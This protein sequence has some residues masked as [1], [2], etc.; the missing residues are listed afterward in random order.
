M[1]EV[2]ALVGGFIGVRIG[3]AAAVGAGG[4]GRIDDAAS[5]GGERTDD[6]AMI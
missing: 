4:V 1:A 6:A 5:T 2:A 3:W